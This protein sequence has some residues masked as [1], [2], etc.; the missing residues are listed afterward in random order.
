MK[1][2]AI[3]AFA[4]MLALGACG[5]NDT[6]MTNSNADNMMAT[7]LGTE[8]NLAD[9]AMMADAMMSPSQT[10]VN[11]VGA[12][13]YF[14]VEAGK[15]A[16]EKA[17]AAPLKQFGAMMVEQHNTSTQKLMAAAGKATPA[18]VP[19]PALTAEQEA[20]LSA[21]RAAE[22]TAFDTLYKTQQIAAHEMALSLVQGYATSGDVP[23]LKTFA[24]DAGKLI[25]A[26][27]TK[28]QDM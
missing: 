28:I 18:I 22:G 10:F 26:H 15:L 8:A 19:N 11:A 24:T 2:L 1:T 23:E 20:N 14:E 6:A 5:G 16:Q 21:L 3:L 12:S 9:N 4:P 25:Q 17:T 13:D 7:D 27:L